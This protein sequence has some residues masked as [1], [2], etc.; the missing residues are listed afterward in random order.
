MDFEQEYIPH[1]YC[2]LTIPPK[3]GPDG[4]PEFAM[5][6]EHLHIWPRHKFMM[7][8]LPNPV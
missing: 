2:E 6:P 8:A 5:D 1:G 3:I 7:I 4:Q